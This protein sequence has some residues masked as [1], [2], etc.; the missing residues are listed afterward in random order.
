MQIVD[1]IHIITPVKDSIDLTLK[2]IEA[3]MQSDMK[4]P[5]VYTVYNDFSTESNTLILEKASKEMGF[6]LVNLSDLTDRPSPNYLLVLQMAQ[7]RA[8][9]EGAG[10]LI[11]ESDVVVDKDTIQKLVEGAESRDKCGI[12]ASVTVD[13]N[14]AINYP[15]LYVKGRENRIVE[16][17]KHLSFCCSLLMPEFLSRYSFHSLNPEKS[18]YDVT[19]SRQSL[20][21]DFKNYLF[22]N[23]P[24]LHRPHSSRPWKLLKYTN[25]VKYYWLKFIHKRDKI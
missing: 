11:V 3:V 21:L 17:N 18:W 19:I 4:C 24:V 12:A 8:L 20:K 16:V 15:Y 2:T 9:K 14:G 1:K 25:P 5:F 7:E 6:E 22:T 23:L 13:E 10:L